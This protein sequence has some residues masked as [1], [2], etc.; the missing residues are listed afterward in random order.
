MSAARNEASRM[1]A[2]M[3]AT[4]DLHDEPNGRREEVSDV[5]VTERHRALERSAQHAT[6]Q[7]FATAPLP[8][9]NHAERLTSLSRV[10]AA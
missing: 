8:T 7:R 5:T 1:A 6:A 2:A 4:V 10:P 9:N 3:H